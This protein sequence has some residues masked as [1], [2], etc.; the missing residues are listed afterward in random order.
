M[1]IGELA[2]AFNHMKDGLATREAKITELA[3]RDQLTGL[4][5]RILFHDRLEQAAKLTS[6]AGRTLRY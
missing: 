1:R 3:Y 5:N 4:P 2:S 6:R